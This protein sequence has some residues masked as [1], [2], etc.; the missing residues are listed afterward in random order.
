MSF[1]AEDGRVSKATALFCAPKHYHFADPKL[2]LSLSPDGRHIRVRAVSFAKGV[3]I[4][5]DDGNLR[6][7]DNFFDMEA[8]ERTLEILPPSAWC[9]KGQPAG[10]YSVQ[11]LYDSYEH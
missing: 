10:P 1:F 3:A 5:S 2:S 8:G 4:S 6:L 7:S 11:S 9:A